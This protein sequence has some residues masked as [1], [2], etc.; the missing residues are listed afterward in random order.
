MRARSRGR[1]CWRRGRGEARRGEGR[2]EAGL[3][4]SWTR[5]LGGD[6]AGSARRRRARSVD[7]RR[8]G[9][10]ADRF[11]EGEDAAWRLARGEGEGKT[12]WTRR[13]G[14]RTRCGPSRREIAPTRRSS[15]P[16]EHLSTEH[17]PPDSVPDSLRL[18]GLVSA[19][20][21]SVDQRRGE[22]LTAGLVSRD[23]A[24]NP[25]RRGSLATGLSP[26]GAVARMRSTCVLATR[27]PAPA[28]RGVRERP[29]H[30]PQRL[31]SRPR[32]LPHVAT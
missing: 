1:G 17:R 11:G 29:E 7:G 26:V 23:R 2:I 22:D 18:R 32:G 31:R 28:R 24:A 12:R 27:G 3:V 16:R 15:D 10:R 14:H 5:G 19:T 30:S 21:G 9:R 13:R 4:D 6:P 8:R 20:Q 25:P